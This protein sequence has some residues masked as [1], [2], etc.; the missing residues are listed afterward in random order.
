[1]EIHARLGVGGNGTV[2]TAAA[3]T[4]RSTVNIYPDFFMLM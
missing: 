3:V 4:F 2:A 1:M